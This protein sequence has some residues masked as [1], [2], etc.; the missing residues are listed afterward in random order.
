MYRFSPSRGM[1]DVLDS[2][3]GTALD[4]GFFGGGVFRKSC[5][6]LEF[7][8]LCSKSDYQAAVTLAHPENIAPI[9]A[10]PVV[11]APSGDLLTTPP[12]SGAAAQQTVDDLLAQQA[13]DWLAQNVQT[14]QD[15]QANLDRSAAVYDQAAASSSF[16]L[17]GVS[18][19]WW[20]AGGLGMFAL[21]SMGGGSPRRY[22]R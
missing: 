10:P 22:G 14:M 5:W 20:L 18:W 21:V 17:G 2:Q 9:Q 13:R 7:P 15:T 1:G 8:S 16:S 19:Y 4:C 11:G 12:E 3:A 6:C